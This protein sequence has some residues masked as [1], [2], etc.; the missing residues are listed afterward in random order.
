MVEPDFF[1]GERP[2]KEKV[3][4]KPHHATYHSIVQPYVCGG[5]RVPRSP[6]GTVPLLVSA[7][8][9]TSDNGGYVNQAGQANQAAPTLLT[10]LTHLITLILSKL[11]SR[12]RA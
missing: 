10:I 6:L 9:A 7:T 3:P 11:S 1:P 12:V 5:T 2:L 8:C 4:H